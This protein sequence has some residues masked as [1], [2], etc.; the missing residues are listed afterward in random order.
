MAHKKKQLEEMLE[1]FISNI[2]FVPVMGAELE[3]YHESL[4]IEDAIVKCIAS[5]IGIDAIYAEEGKF[6]YEVSF[7]KTANIVQL[8]C[9]IEK[10]KQI[11]DGDFSAKPYEDDYGNSMQIHVSL[12]DKEQVNIFEKAGEGESSSMQNAIAGLLDTMLDNMHIFA[13]NVNCYN[14]LSKGKGAPSTVSWGGNNRTVALR[15][16]VTTIDPQN[17]RIE[18]RVSSADA[19]AYLVIGAILGGLTKGILEKKLPKSPKIYGDASLDMYGLPSLLIESK[20]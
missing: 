4:V 10:F 15:L 16:P 19:D 6:Q 17:R 5:G 8:A 20:K 2:F 13:P 12:L 3:F 1:K 11:I 14:R 9:D 7:R 18:H